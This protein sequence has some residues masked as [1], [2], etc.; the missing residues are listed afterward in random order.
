MLVSQ[1][2]RWVLLQKYQTVIYKASL[3]YLHWESR[4]LD[5]NQELR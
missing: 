2:G 4:N 5:Q 1:I 3:I